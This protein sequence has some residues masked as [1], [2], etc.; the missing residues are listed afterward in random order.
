[1]QASGKEQTS[2]NHINHIRHIRKPLIF[3]SI[4]SFITTLMRIL[5]SMALTSSLAR[6]GLRHGINI[7]V[8]RLNAFQ[9]ISYLTPSIFI[10][11]LKT[12]GSADV[13]KLLYRGVE[14]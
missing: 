10:F 6:G 3:S 14:L 1:M 7:D 4:T 12:Q 13:E 2:D 11:D 8:P 9:L 5:R